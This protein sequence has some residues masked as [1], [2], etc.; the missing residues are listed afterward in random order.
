MCDGALC[1]M[2]LTIQGG[3]YLTPA[4]STQLLSLANNANPDDTCGPAL[5]E[6]GQ[7]AGGPAKAA[8]IGIGSGTD[9]EAKLFTGLALM[10]SGTVT[11]TSLE[12]RMEYPLGHVDYV[13]DFK[14][15]D[16]E[17]LQQLVGSTDVESFPRVRPNSYS[18]K[19]V[20]K[21]KQATY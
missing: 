4:R 12:R 9:G 2:V 7:R 3:L 17:T 10:V 15:L 20:A 14:P 18:M 16:A 6:F 8:N 13:Y 19:L 11:A 21:R 5:G 1:R